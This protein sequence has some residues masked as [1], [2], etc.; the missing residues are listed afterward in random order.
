MWGEEEDTR[1]DF[2]IPA[3]LVRWWDEHDIVHDALQPKTTGNT[4]AMEQSWV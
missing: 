1:Y 4:P 3:L 2:R